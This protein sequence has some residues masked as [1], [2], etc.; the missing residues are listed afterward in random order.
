MGDI[1]EKVGLLWAARNFYYYNFSLCLNQYMKF[2]EA[3]PVLFLSAHA[4]KLIE[5]RL[6]HILYAI[7]FNTLAYISE[8]MYPD[9]IKSDEE[10]D[11]FDY[12]LA[13]QILRT[14]YEVEK[15]LGQLPSYL[16]KH[17]LT[18]SSAAMKYEL[19]YYDETILEALNSN[20]EA[21]DD[22]IGK[23]SAQPALDRLNYLPWYG[24]EPSCMMQT[25]LLGCFI[26]LNVNGPYNHG[27]IEIGA[28]ILATIES[29]FWNRSSQR[30]YFFNCK[31]WNKTSI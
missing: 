4:L 8:H 24:V 9:K 14:S 31:N 11:N 22:L 27:E 5:L 1:F 25:N 26:E 15:S 29:F 19:G 30:S 3:L 6:G 21:F 18:F 10:Q 16:E 7:N 2:G 13:I 20:T 17:G 28:T 12:I 23:W